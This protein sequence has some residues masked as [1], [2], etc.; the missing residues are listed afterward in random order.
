M[1]MTHLKALPIILA[2][3]LLTSL[4]A[5]AQNTSSDLTQL[6]T[7]DWPTNGGDI[8][9]R[10]YSPLTEINRDTVSGLTGVWRTHLGGSGAGPRNSGEGQ[11]I[12]FDGVAYISTGD[13][14]VF[15]ISIETG[16][17]LWQ[18]RANLDNTIS[19]VCCGWISRGVGIGEGLI[20]IG[21]LDAKL[22]ALD[23]ETGEV[24]W[25]TQ[26]ERWQDSY[27]ITSAPLYYDGLVVTGFSGSELGVRGRIKAYDAKD[28]S[29]VW[30]FNTSPG[31]GEFGH[32]TWQA[33]NEV[34][35][36]GGASVWQT[37]SVDPELGMIYFSTANP[38][39]SY[40]GSVRAGDNLF[41]ASIVALDVKTG[42]YRWHFQEVHHDIWDYD[43]PNPVI[44]FDLEIKGEMRKGLAQ[45]GKTGWVYILDRISGEPLIGIEER[46]VLQEPRMATAATQPYPI[47][48]AFVPQ[49][50]DIAPEGY[51]L[52]NDGKIFTPFWTDELV[53]IAPGMPG[54]ANWPPSSYDP[55]TGH[56]FI[57]AA[58][59]P[60]AFG[61]L[62]VSD[63]NPEPGALYTAGT[64]AFVLHDIGIFAAMD[65]HTN[66][67]VWQQQ[68]KEPCFS[69]ATST[70]GG[71]VFTG[72]NDGRLTA[73][74]TRDGSKLWEFQTGA[75]MNAP[76]SIFE[77]K[78]TQYVIAYSAG[79]LLAPSVRGDSLWLFSLEGEMDQAAPG[80]ASFGPPIT[81]E[82]V[83]VAGGE[84]DLEAGKIV[85]QS[86]CS[87]CHG[88]DGKGGHG[89]GAS[90][91]NSH[92]IAPIIE[93]I[94][95]GRNKMPSLSAAFSPE[96]MRDVAAYV[97]SELAE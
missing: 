86:T 76:V 3:S 69:G 87:A 15:A 73:L 28:G 93:I 97:V 23:Q 35:K 88:P 77:Y 65:L 68:W 43:A 74:D 51:K 55:T 46:P 37:P 19:T 27:T 72:R 47:G 32:D 7:T 11:P 90:L 50:I 8:Y 78:G 53:L 4:S 34:W 10:R 91:E 75:G 24:V 33:D 31:P 9:N 54:G 58:H 80:V 52:I 64:G 61:A 89:G 22:V 83:E 70:A 21:Q 84:A 14:D 66:T 56:M 92:E 12:V 39:P 96:E 62:E 85:F 57:C 81:S 41:S 63:E 26:A 45:A 25:E 17:I 94:T 71:L 16:E 6:P 44:L 20:Y 30:T 36:S 13:D 38:G 67:L 59:R 5:C 79:N 42:E 29:L 18:Y 60:Y 48:D 95:Q 49:S 82:A 40:N 1:K 2:L